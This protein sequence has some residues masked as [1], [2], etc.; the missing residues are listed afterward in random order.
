MVALYIKHLVPG[1]FAY[2]LLNNILRFLQTQSIVYPLVL[3]SLIPLILHIGI[4]YVLVY[5]TSLAFV[6]AA[7]AV[8]VSLWIAV[9]MLAGYVLL[10]DGLRK[11]GK[12]SP[13]S[14]LIILEYWAFELLVLL[15]WIL[16]NSEITTS[17]IAMCVNTE[18]IAY[19][20]TY[21]LSAAASTRVSSEVGASNIDRAKHAMAVTLKLSVVLALAVVLALCFGHDIWA[22]LF[23]DSHVIIE[24]FASMTPLLMIS[25]ILDSIRGVLSGVVDWL[26][27]WSLMSN[28]KP[29]TTRVSQKV[30]ASGTRW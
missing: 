13:W 7:V 21:G 20:L 22:S 23:S 17:L 27:M 26:D 14:R 29:S 1:L 9:L 15:A 8:S 25:I 16:P 11:H 28:R 30:D 4:T 3:C 10:A 5:H 18:A 19:M 6:G 24:E 12:V 2:G